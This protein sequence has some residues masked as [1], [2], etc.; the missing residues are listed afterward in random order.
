MFSTLKR[1]LQYHFRK[2]ENLRAYTLLSPTL[3]III[4]TMG[5]PLV[6]SVVYSFWTQFYLEI[7][8]TFTLANYIK[9]FDRPI[10]IELI[11]RSM[12]IS[13]MVTLVTILTAYPIA[14]YVAFHVK[15]NKIFWIIL[16]TLPFW[17]SYLLRVFAW[18]LIL[19]YE[20]IINGSLI[21]LG[22]I[23]EPIAVLLHSPE[24]VVITLAH[25]WAAFAVLPIF[26]SL[27][28]I[29][30][31]Y[32]EAS[33]DLGHGPVSSFLRVT[34]PLSMPGVISAA[35]VIFIPTVAD[36]VTPSLVGGPDGRMVANLIQILY[37]RGNDWPMG[38]A[39][40]LM[41]IIYISA[42][43]GTFILIA[44]ILRRGGMG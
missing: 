1:S 39:L 13:G 5:V 25:A 8:K 9:F 16:M 2:S 20:G 40:S 11:K 37:G 15:K 35:L 21:K 30:K 17:T 6:M 18:K 3:L 24:A 7:D 12:K 32:L 43:C 42:V 36:Y 28:N 22:L 4:L 34:L 27:D 10:Y 41:M 44:R 31:S 26:V 14:Y 23:S 33:A 29:D 38:S 19:G